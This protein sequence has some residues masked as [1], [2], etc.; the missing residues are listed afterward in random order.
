MRTCPTSLEF[1]RPQG[2]R[3]V[4]RINW[5][6]GYWCRSSRCDWDLELRLKLTCGYLH[7]IMQLCMTEYLVHGPA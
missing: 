6:V 3:G 5:V 4:W 1:A 2:D 7:N